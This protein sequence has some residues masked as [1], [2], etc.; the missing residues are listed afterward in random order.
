LDEIDKKKKKL[1]NSIADLKE[2]KGVYTELMNDAESVLFLY[3][4]ATS[5]PKE[6]GGYPERLNN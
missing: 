6:L 2:S 4:F 5:F 3:C 1:K